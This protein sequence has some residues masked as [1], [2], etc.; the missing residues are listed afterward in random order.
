MLSILFILCL[1]EI[2]LDG[3]NTITEV[4]MTIC[5]WRELEMDDISLYLRLIDKL[6]IIYE[7]GWG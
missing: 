6:Y 7:L 2:F 3:I 4:G 1:M 5:L